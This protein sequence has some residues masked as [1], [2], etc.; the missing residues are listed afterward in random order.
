MSMLKSFR[1]RQDQFCRF[2]CR[3]LALSNGL[4][5]IETVDKLADNEHRS[6]VL[7]KFMNGHNVWVLQ[8]GGGLRLPQETL[9]RIVIHFRSSRNLYRHLAV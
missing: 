4:R 1:H 8:T 5:Q 7:P 2:A 3:V 6:I 9:H